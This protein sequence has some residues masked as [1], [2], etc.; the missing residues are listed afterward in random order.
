MAGGVRRRQLSSSRVFPPR[1]GWFFSF[2]LLSVKEVASLCLD[3]HGLLFCGQIRGAYNDFLFWFSCLL[4]TFRSFS[5]KQQL[6]R[7]Q[8]AKAVHSELLNTH[9]D[10]AIEMVGR[11]PFYFSPVHI[12]CPKDPPTP[13]LS[14]AGCWLFTI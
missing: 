7:D 3:F 1:Q 2:I 6:F 14:T 8:G 12:Y 4:S 13:L 5:G 11:P 10:G 9:S